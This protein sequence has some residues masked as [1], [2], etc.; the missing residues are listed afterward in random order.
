MKAFPSH[1]FFDWTNDGVLQINC[2]DCPFL[3]DNGKCSTFDIRTCPTEA[4]VAKYRKSLQLT[5]KKNRRK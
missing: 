3:F 1:K 2:V 5:P 4:S